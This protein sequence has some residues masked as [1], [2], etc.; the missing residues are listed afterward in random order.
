MAGLGRPQ[1]RRSRRPPAP[2]P[3]R[4]SRPAPRTIPIPP[5]TFMVSLFRPAPTATARYRRT[6]WRRTWAAGDGRP[7][8]RAGSGHGPNESGVT[9][10]TPVLIESTKTLNCTPVQRGSVRGPSREGSVLPREG[11]AA[12]ANDVEHAPTPGIAVPADGRSD[13]TERGR[14]RILRAALEEFAIR[15]STERPPR[16][17]PARPG[18][19]TARALPLHLADRPLA[20]GGPH[21]FGVRPG[22]SRA[23]RTSSATSRAS[24]R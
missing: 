17:S 22:R 14:E 24:T 8:A 11:E 13:L 2:W 23:W 21:L 12:M 6:G 4:P 3:R 9:P 1:R 5:S 18:H 20:G 16:R 7:P 10:C 19:P 15:A